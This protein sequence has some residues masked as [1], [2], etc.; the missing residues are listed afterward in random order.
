[1]NVAALSV[2]SGGGR[3]HAGT[4]LRRRQGNKSCLRRWAAL[5]GAG[6]PARVRGSATPWQPNATPPQ[7]GGMSFV[8]QGVARRGG[9]TTRYPPPQ[10]AAARGL[11]WGLSGRPPP[12]RAH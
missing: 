6:L 8:C 1:M 12:G 7:F 10:T 2:A 9:G 4:R 5:R 3:H 11:R